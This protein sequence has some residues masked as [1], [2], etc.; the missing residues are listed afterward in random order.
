MSKSGGGCDVIVALRMEKHAYGRAR[1]CWRRPPPTQ[2]N[3]SE[4]DMRCTSLRVTFNS[5]PIIRDQVPEMYERSELPSSLCLSV[6]LSLC[7]SVPSSL[8]TSVLAYRGWV[9]VCV[10]RISPRSV[11]VWFVSRS[12][13]LFCR[14]CLFSYIVFFRGYGLGLLCSW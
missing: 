2:P 1:T 3:D 5:H 12:W 13:C 9:G 4:A 8:R 6:P 7:P 10:P 11:S 14:F